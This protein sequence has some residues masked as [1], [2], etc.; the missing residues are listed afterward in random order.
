[1][2]MSIIVGVLLVALKLIILFY[3]F[4]QLDWIVV[5][6]IIGVF[7]YIDIIEH[8]L[9]TGRWSLTND[10]NAMGMRADVVVDELREKIANLEDQVK[11]LQSETARIKRLARIVDGG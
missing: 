6:L 2:Y 4:V 8:H 10:V 3:P 7:I 1:M 9:V 5:I 11:E